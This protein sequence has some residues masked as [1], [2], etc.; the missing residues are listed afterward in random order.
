MR[1]HQPGRI[2]RAPG[3][4]TADKGGS[5]PDHVRVDL[6]NKLGNCRGSVRHCAHMEEQ[7]LGRGQI[8][9][10]TFVEGAG[11]IRDR[12]GR[13]TPEAIGILNGGVVLEPPER[14]ICL[15]DLIG[16]AHDVAAIWAQNRHLAMREVGDW[17]A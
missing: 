9:M 15:L 12:A 1:R 11:F 8:G 17:D 2:K 13:C 14:R 7:R 16:N 3:I 4:L 5:R 6:G 10:G